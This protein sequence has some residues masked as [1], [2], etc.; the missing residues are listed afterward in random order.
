MTSEQK[1]SPHL[2]EPDRPADVW[3]KEVRHEHRYLE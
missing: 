1:P 3:F 2:Q